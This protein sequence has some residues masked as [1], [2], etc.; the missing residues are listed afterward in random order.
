MFQ[1]FGIHVFSGFESFI[2]KMKR[3]TF[4]TN[5]FTWQKTF[6]NLAKIC[7]CTVKILT[8]IFWEVIY[9]FLIKPR[10][11]KSEK[12]SK[13]V[14]RFGTYRSWK[15]CSMVFENS[16]LEIRKTHHYAKQVYIGHFKLYYSSVHI[17]ESM[18]FWKAFCLFSWN[19]TRI[20]LQDLKLISSRSRTEFTFSLVR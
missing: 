6:A 9:S 8:M 12:V 2:W 11:L 13:M 4:W 20:R 15:W 14:S 5:Y 1:F 17:N 3:K 7:K 10:W 19:Q 18:F 16:F